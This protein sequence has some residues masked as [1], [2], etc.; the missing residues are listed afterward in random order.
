VTVTLDKDVEAF[1][2][3]PRQLFINGQW[4]DAAS[5][6]TFDTPNPATGETLARVAEGDAEDINR[7][8]RAARAAF[9]GPWSRMSPSERGRIIWRIGDLI[10]EHADEL[11]QLESLD[12]GKPFA[13]ARAADVPLAAD[14]F[15]YMAGWATK[16]E[17]N[18]INI[19][20]PYMPGAN[21]HSYTLREPLGVVGQIIPW[22]FPLLM[23]AWKLGPALATGNCV[24]LKPAEQTPLT[25]LRLAGLIAEAGVP[26][27]VVNVVPGF[28][29]TAGAALTAHP[30]VD[31]VAFTGS[32]AVGKLIVAASAAS[33][34]K[35]LTLELGGKSPNIVFDDAGPDAIAGAANA[36][37]F[38]HGQCCVAGSRLY[39]QQSRF[40]EVVDGVAQI[41]KSIKIGPGMEPGTQM[42]P[43]VSEEQLRLVTGFLESG[44]AEGATA[45]A[46]GGRFGDRGYFVEPTVLTNTRPDMKVVREEIFGPVLVAAP[47][48]DLDEIAAVANDSD[49]G[50]GAGIWTKDI[51]KAHALA[52]KLRAGT[53]WINCYNVFDAALPFGG[54]KQSGWGREMGHEALNAYT[55]VKAVTTQL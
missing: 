38:N 34:L 9:E 11:A 1:V 54:Y 50:L 33:N 31:K 16:I 26:D 46:G 28:G 22:N 43:L 15:H 48:S 2:A 7:A 18:S 5:G 52:K 12:N 42:G 53:V 17:G 4:T 45:L 39:V 21:F 13:V 32:T 19:S 41:A 47:F 37:F 35:K 25:A 40:D 23:A 14:L 8:V 49:F 30:D 44:E 51:S 36:I 27:G 20:V 6:Q 24:V 29:E 3:T 55:E 10:L